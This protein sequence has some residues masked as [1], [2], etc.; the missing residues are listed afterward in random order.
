VPEWLRTIGQGFL[1]LLLWAGFIGY[2]LIFV[3]LKV[4]GYLFWLIPAAGFTLLLS[5]FLLFAHL[6]NKTEKQRTQRKQAE[7]ET[8]LR[9]PE[10]M[11]WQEAEREKQR[12]QQEVD[13]R[14]R[15]EAEESAAREKWRLYHESKTMDEISMM[16]GTEF[17]EFLARLFS[18]MGYADIQLTPV[19]DQGGDLLCLS[20]SGRRIVIQAK[21]WKGSVGNEAVQ[22]LLGAM[23]NYGCTEG[24]VVTNSTFTQAAYELAKKGSDVVLRDGRWLEEQIKTFLPPEIPEFS[25]EEYKR[26]VKDYQPPHTRGA[27]RTNFGRRSRRRWYY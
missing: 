16:S 5:V 24:M 18:R 7:H 25:W 19:N 8:W 22:E 3:E 23:R 13:E 14:R 10:G 27:K 26:V 21:R 2:A 20:P 17:E 12:K 11:A 1:Y 4:P 6:K 9:T 15:K